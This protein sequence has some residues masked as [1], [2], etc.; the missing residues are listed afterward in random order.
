MAKSKKTA[1]L[2]H[3]LAPTVADLEYTIPLVWKDGMPVVTGAPVRLSRDPSVS[4]PELLRACLDLPYDGPDPS[5]A[6]RTLGEAMIVNL[7]RQAASGDHDAR[8]TILDRILGKPKQSIESVTLSGDLNDF[9]DKVAK[10]TIIDTVP[11]YVDTPVD[12]SVEDL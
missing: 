5:L 1:L 2:R 3:M 10:E 11:E 4:V 8:T 12:N 9:L 6:G 7:T